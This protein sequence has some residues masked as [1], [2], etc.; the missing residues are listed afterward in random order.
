MTTADAD[1]TTSPG[2]VVVAEAVAVRQ[3]GRELLREVTLDVRRGR[4][5]VLRG[6]SGAG[7]STLLRCLNGLVWPDAGVV[8]LD[9]ADLRSLP[10]P[11]VRRRVALVSQTPVMLPGTVADNLAYG[12]ASPGPDR[13]TRAAAAAALPSALLDRDA[14]ELSGGER[15]RVAIARALTRDPEVLLLDEPTA[16][17]DA[18]AAATITTTVRALADT[19]LAVV[20]ATHDDTLAAAIADEVATLPT[21]GRGAG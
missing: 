18:D 3:G 12:L 6:P 20:V 2:P 9:G 1:A 5:L 21:G 8:R 4:V 16:A 10:A 15:A 17:L 19:G 11:A 13:L 14:A 7:K